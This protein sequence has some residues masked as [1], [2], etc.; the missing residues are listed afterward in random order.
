MGDDLHYQHGDQSSCNCTSLNSAWRSKTNEVPH[1]K[2]ERASLTSR[3]TWQFWALRRQF[4]GVLW[5]SWQVYYRRKG[6]KSLLYG[7]TVE[8]S[9]SVLVIARGKRLRARKINRKFVGSN[10]RSFIDCVVQT[11]HHPD[12]TTLIPLRSYILLPA[13]SVCVIFV[14]PSQRLKPFIPILSVPFY[15]YNANYVDKYETFYVDT[16]ATPFCTLFH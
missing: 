16:I 9:T 2:G 15:Y 13:R 3:R 8:S 4:R 6:Q 11:H 1:I 7:T 14:L 12:G 10:K 5:T